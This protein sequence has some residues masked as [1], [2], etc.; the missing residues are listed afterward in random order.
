MLRHIGIIGLIY[1]TVA[2]QSSVVT[3]EFV[4][5]ARPFL[6]AILLVI[7][8]VWCDGAAAIF[9]SGCLGIVLDGLSP[10]RLG[11]QL[12][13]AALLGL[14]LQ[15]G[16]SAS[17]SRGLLALTAAVFVVSMVW[18]VLSPMTCAVLAGRVVDAGAVVSSAARDATS[19][20]VVGFVVICLGRALLASPSRR[21]DAVPGLSNR[22]GMLT[23]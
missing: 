19:T 13:L 20:S 16:K 23:E 14:G 5:Q 21:E 11:I 3:E 6:P 8:A 2:L 10:E 1:L 7:I 15:L 9:W 22:W 4:A 12:S 17:R 18:R